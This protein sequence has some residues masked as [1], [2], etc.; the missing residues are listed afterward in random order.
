[1]RCGWNYAPN[2]GRG[3]GEKLSSLNAVSRRVFTLKCVS[4]SKLY[5]LYMKICFI[6]FRM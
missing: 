2:R 5:F 6:Y 4:G 1:M 3:C